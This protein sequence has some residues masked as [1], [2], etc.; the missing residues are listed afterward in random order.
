MK[1]RLTKMMEKKIEQRAARVLSAFDYKDGEDMY[2]DAVRL[3]AFF[4]FVVDQKDM[5]ANE[6]GCVSV[7]ENQEDKSI[8]VNINRS[9]ETKR[10]IITHELAHYLLH[11]SGEN[12]FFMHRENTKGKNLEENDADYLAAC[13]LMPPKSFKKE[14]DRLKKNKYTHSEIVRELQE[15]FRTPIES[16]ERRIIEI[17]V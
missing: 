17:C 8:E 9:I 14:F 7:S 6:D 5:P 16:I 10:F 1:K 2:V 15:K 11:Y 4:G 13:L 3:S 12:H